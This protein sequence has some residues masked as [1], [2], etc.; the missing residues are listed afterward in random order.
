MEGL[1]SIESYEGMEELERLR[2]AHK[3]MEQ[4]ERTK[5]FMTALE[6]IANDK[7]TVNLFSRLGK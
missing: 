1:E 4:A 6:K 2:K 3:D 5:L 7:K